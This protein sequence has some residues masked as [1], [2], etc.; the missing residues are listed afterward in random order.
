MFVRTESSDLTSIG[1]VSSVTFPY[2]ATK[3]GLIVVSSIN[4]GG[5][6]DCYLYFLRGSTQFRYRGY[7]SSASCY[8]Q[9]VIP[10]SAGDTVTIDASIASSYTAEFRAL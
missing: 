1:S 3:N 6:G 5:T 10:V 4:S 7:H 9:L 8:G 2:T